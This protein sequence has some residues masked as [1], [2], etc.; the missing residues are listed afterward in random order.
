MLRKCGLFAL[1]F[2]ALSISSSVFFSDVSS[3]TSPYDANYVKRDNLRVSM[4]GCDAVSMTDNPLDGLHPSGGTRY[5][6]EN[7]KPFD[8]FIDAMNNGGRWGMSGTDNDY[9]IYWTPDDSLYLDWTSYSGAVMARGNNL[10]MANV[11]QMGNSGQET[12]QINL[13]GY[14]SDLT[15][16]PVSWPANNIKNLYV[17]TDHYNYPEGYAGVSIPNSFTANDEV[18]T[19]N[20]NWT[21]SKDG[22]LHITYLKNLPHFLTGSSYVVV[23]EMTTKWQG[24]GAEVH[25][26]VYQ[27]A[28][29]LDDDIMTV[30]ANKYYMV[31]ISHDQQLDS[32]PWPTGPTPAIK[33]VWIQFYWDGKTALNGT[34]VGCTADICNDQ[35]SE[36]SPTQSL[37]KSLDNIQT[38]GLQQFFVAPINFYATLPAMVNTCTPINLPFLSQNISL[39]CLKSRYYVWSSSIMAIWS[40]VLTAGVAYLIAMNIFRTIKN[41]NS[42]DEDRIE[43]AKL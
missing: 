27:P 16:T 1:L 29:W 41:V 7:P 24:L 17:N 28:G 42:P 12:C 15:V 13:L 6:T 34:N 3:A 20:Y 35:L 32:P 43:V 9:T 22:K 31:R 30:Q 10:H 38:F 36:D 14:Y 19:P 5:Q 40:T 4:W 21:V 8:S 39:S 25:N 18:L 11:G 37:F 23:N 2:T 26:Q 33:N